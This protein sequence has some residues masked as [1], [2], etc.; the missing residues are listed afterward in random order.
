MIGEQLIKELNEKDN[1]KEHGFE[2]F[3]DDGENQLFVKM[4]EYGVLLIIIFRDEFV[5]VVYSEDVKGWNIS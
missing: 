3:G 5:Y 1:Y 4:C 2:M